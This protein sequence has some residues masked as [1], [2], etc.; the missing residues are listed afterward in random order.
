MTQTGLEPDDSTYSY[1]I[2]ALCKREVETQ[3]T[4]AML[5]RQAE[6]AGTTDAHDV[7]ALLAED[8]LAKALGLFDAATAASMTLSVE[9]ANQ[10]LRVLSHKPDQAACARIYAS[11]TAPTC[12]TFGSLVHM[13]GRLGDL[14]LALE[15]YAQGRAREHD[16]QLEHAL[17]EA[18]LRCDRVDDALAHIE[19]EL[20]GDMVAYN[21]VV[22][23][24][25]A[26]ARLADA[27]ALVSRLPKPD[28]SSYGPLLAAYCQA[29]AWE[30]AQP[31][32]RA[33]L[34][35][36]LSKSYGNLANYAMLCLKHDHT[37]KALDVVRAMQRARLEPDALLAERIVRAATAVQLQSGIHALQVV[38]EA[39]SSRALAKA[40]DRLTQLTIEMGAHTSLDL[41]HVLAI[42]RVV[43]AYMPYYK[44]PAELGRRILTCAVDNDCPLVLQ[45]FV[46]L[47]QAAVAEPEQ[48]QPNMRGFVQ[49]LVTLM[50]AAG[51]STTDLPR[52]LVVRVLGC[53]GEDEEVRALF[54]NG[55]QLLPEVEAASKD[56]MRCVMRGDMKQA[57]Q[58]LCDVLEQG[59]TPSLEPVRDAIALAG[60]QG[61]LTEAQTMYDVCKK[62][63]G[64]NKQA[65]YMVT[66]SI[67]IGYA[68]Q[69]RMHEAKVYYD[70]IKRMGLYPDGNA[71]ASLLLGTAQSTS[72]TDEASDALII[73]EEAKKHK[74][75][76]TTFFYNVVISKLAKARKLEAALRL[77]DEMQNLFD[78][79]PNTI[80]FGAVISACVRAGSESHA[81]RLFDAMLL[82]PAAS[83]RIGPFNNMIQFYVRQQPDRSRALAY[84]AEIRR[85]GL[86]PTAHT[87]KLLMEAYSMLAPYDMETAHSLLDSMREEDALEPQATHYATLIYAYGT[88]QH[89]VSAAQR[90]FDD[91]ACLR[92]EVVYQ[93]MLDTLITHH[94]LDR[95]EAVYHEMQSAIMKSSS[96]YIENLLLRG[97]GQAGRLDKAEALFERMSDDKSI[98]TP[99][100]VVREPSTYEAMVRAYL[101]NAKVTQAK[102]I[103]DRMARRHFPE[104]VVA[105]VAALFTN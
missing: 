59:H 16:V 49:R 15:Y 99:G 8:N 9:A 83:L 31:I 95:A 2:R 34:T 6:R 11:I 30:L 74:V 32:Y 1:L 43:L 71:Y 88:L 20:V 10:L 53:L 45:D 73:Y 85:H 60:K 75:R 50:R 87:Y 25:C 102:S 100:V 78:L 27:Q 47:Y 46:L 55:V 68:Q 65:I 23:Y 38:T 69:G 96:P 13:A 64:D 91:A 48:A 92:D 5:R 79:T 94:Q 86:T 24:Y 80:T 90:V 76:P 33:L 18:Y 41:T 36:D 97:Y 58:T 22:R 7:D 19:R 4:V 72:T 44:L 103:L 63:L 61:H 82:A 84:F 54:D 56:V 98:R 81:C 39:M 66:N 67:L 37:D 14:P 101:N 77:F 21:S 17:V 29:D 52:D 51:V 70:Q 57:V 62:A 104:K 35:T 28:A 40:A 12:A 105:A 42:G 93:A 26:Q 89:N 3:K